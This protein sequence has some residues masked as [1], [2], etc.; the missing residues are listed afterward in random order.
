MIWLWLINLFLISLLSFPLAVRINASLSKILGLMIFTYLTWLISFLVDFRSAVL[1]GFLIYVTIGSMFWISVR[2]LRLFE[3]LK[4]EALFLA[5]FLLYISYELFNPDIFGAEKLSDVAILSAILKSDGMPPLD[6]NLAGYRLD[7]YYYMGYVIYATLTILS[8]EKI[9]IAY[10]LACATVFALT[11]STLIPF[12]F[13]NGKFAIPF[14]LLAGNLKTIEMILLGDIKKAFDFWTVTRVIEGTINEFP[15]ATLFFRD[16]HPHFMSIP[17]QIA[18]LISLYDWMKKERKSNLAFMTFLLGFM[19]T[20]NSWDF[21]TYLLILTISILIKKRYYAFS[22]LPLSILPFLPFYLTLNATAVKGV[23]FVIQRTDLLSFVTA[24]P[25]IL[26]PLSY[27]LFEDFKTFLKAFIVS[28]PAFF[29]GQVF[30]ITIPLLIVFLKFLLEEGKF[31]HVMIFTALLILSAVEIVYLDDP[32]SG[33]VERLNTVFKT[34]VQAWIILSFGFLYREKCKIFVLFLILT[35]WIY[36]FGCAFGL[37]EIKGLDGIAYTK[38]YGEYDALNFLQRFEGVV[39][40]YPGNTPFESY[41]YSGRVSAYTGLQSVLCN[42]GHEFFWRY[43]GNIVGVLSERWSEIK[44]IYESD[45]LNYTI[46]KKYNVSFIYIGYLERKN[47]NIKFEKFSS[48]KKVY[49][50]GYVV[51]YRVIYPEV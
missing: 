40:E 12:A 11:M 9:Q 21:F 48:F 15:L 31:E 28:I 39:V 19:F 3:F 30:I 33:D 36:P 10:N 20:V 46:L 6:P 44:E 24:Q 41:T 35:L 22:F 50:D 8:M 42:G 27:A 29:F 18:F 26:I 34:Y 43:Y 47:Y 5:F 4:F 45:S 49:D 14:L 1:Y 17:L 37:K 2:N 7:C 38:R 13:R 16:L 32:Y 23:G 25:L 51:V